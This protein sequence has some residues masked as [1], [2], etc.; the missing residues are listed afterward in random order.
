MKEMPPPARTRAQLLTDLLVAAARAGDARAFEALVRLWHPRFLA[1]AARLL[2]DRDRAADAVQSA[3]VEIVRGLGSLADVC[4]FPAWAL[5]IVSRRV[6]REIGGAVQTRR[7][8]AALDALPAAAPA[9]DTGDLGAAIARLP[10][11]QR[12]A[13]ALHHVD[14]LSIAEVAIALDCPVGTV[15]TRLMHARAKLRAALE[16]DDA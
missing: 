14:G 5:R 10:P 15:K 3:W 6:A 1:H 4:A 9:R 11:L 8:A 2:G 13:L 7:L 12:A 16:G